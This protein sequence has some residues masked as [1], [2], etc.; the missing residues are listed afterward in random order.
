GRLPPPRVDQGWIAAAFTA[1]E[2]RSVE[3]RAALVLSDAL[4]D[5]LM[6]SDTLVLGGPMYNFGVP[7][8]LKAW[9]DQV[10]RVG[11]TF[12]HVPADPQP[13]QP[14]TAGKQAFVIVTTGDAGYQP[15]GPVAALNQVEPYLRTVLGFIG[16]TAV[17]FIYAG[18]DEFG[19]ER[20]R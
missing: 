19:G 2:Q 10:V 9:S 7:A 14:L 18:Y 17:E 11:R 3:M 15:G 6:A 16:I 4:V 13:Y 8:A 20:L 5:E 12:S 1:F